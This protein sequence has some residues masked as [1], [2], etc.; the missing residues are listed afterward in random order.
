MMRLILHM[1]AVRKT[2]YPFD[3]ISDTFSHIPIGGCLIPNRDNILIKPN[4]HYGSANFI[5]GNL[6]KLPADHGQNDF[7]PVPRGQA[8]FETYDPLPSNN[9]GGVFPG[10][11][12][13]FTEAV[14][15]SCCGKRRRAN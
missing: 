4:T 13:P 11:L 12:D 5:G 2:Q 14:V 6:R 10:G 3:G 8:L 7:L 9:V 15:V 1:H